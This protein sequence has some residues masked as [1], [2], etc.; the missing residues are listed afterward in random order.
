[1][2]TRRALNPAAE[3]SEAL[4]AARAGALILGIPAFVSLLVAV[5]EGRRFGHTLVWGNLISIGLAAWIW[6]RFHNWWKLLRMSRWPMWAWV[7]ATMIVPAVYL[8][9]APL[10]APSLR[11]TGPRAVA[12]L[13]GNVFLVFAW[14]GAVQPR[15][16]SLAIA[17]YAAVCLHLGLSRLGSTV[18][19]TGSTAV[20]VPFGVVL[21]EVIAWI[22]ERMRL[23]RDLDRRRIAAL[24]ELAE[25]IARIR[26]EQSLEEAVAL[27]A[28]VA[29]RSFHGEH[30]A[31]RVERLD[32]TPVEVRLGRHAEGPA[33]D[34]DEMLAR[35]AVSGE[36]KISVL[37]E[38]PV[39]RHLLTVPLVGKSG[40]VGVVSVARVGREDR[41]VLHSAQLFAS[42]A[43]SALEQKRLLEALA[44][45]VELDALTGV[46]NRRRAERLLETLEPRD[47]VVLVDLDEFKS[48][49]DTYGHTAGDELLVD[50]AR[51]LSESVRE[52]DSVA[53]WG[54]DEFLVVLRGVGDDLENVVRRIVETWGAREPRSTISV[55]A[56]LHAE[57]RTGADTFRTADGMLYRAKEAGRNTAR[58]AAE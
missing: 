11:E 9:L 1:M 50:I 35:I 41:F 49:N 17:P 32:G 6:F 29:L 12:L 48:V 7:G 58:V 45:D 43:G 57:G 3:L 14:V 8:A 23:A 51:H 16:T 22:S 28:D 10:H 19:A 55:G 53:R 30:V 47:A 4:F 40:P 56:A 44:A 39:R 54:G 2:D 33:V 21:G 36:V 37:D 46:G 5:A 31:V 20:V 18:D 34:L 13:V 38:A 27:L 24:E 52:S 15:W 26:G 25:A 42:Q